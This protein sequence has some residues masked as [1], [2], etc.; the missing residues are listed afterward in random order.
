MYEKMNT[1]GHAKDR[2]LPQETITLSQIREQTNIQKPQH[3]KPIQVYLCFLLLLNMHV[4][5]II[6]GCTFACMHM[7]LCAS[8]WETCWVSPPSSRA[9]QI[10]VEQ[11]KARRSCF[12]IREAALPCGLISFIYTVEYRNTHTH[13]HEIHKGQQHACA[14]KNVH[15]TRTS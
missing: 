13:A 15:N 7:F 4:W 2:D 1:E 9:Y 3:W 5:I 12:H 11:I 14:N 10:Q 6:S 8:L